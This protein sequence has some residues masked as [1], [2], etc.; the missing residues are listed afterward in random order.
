MEMTNFTLFE[1]DIMYI[2][3][4]LG[5]FIAIKDKLKKTTILK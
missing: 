5:R 1:I 4:Y 3:I 2:S